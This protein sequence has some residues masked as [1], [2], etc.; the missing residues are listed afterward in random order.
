MTRMANEH[1]NN[2]KTNDALRDA[3]TAVLLEHAGEHPSG[4]GLLTDWV[5]LTE[6][7]GDDGK[8]WLRFNYD[9]DTPIWRMIGMLETCAADAKHTFLEINDR[10]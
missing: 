7:V 8:H 10:D 5:L 1:N 4:R 3:I 2:K 6:S 9:T